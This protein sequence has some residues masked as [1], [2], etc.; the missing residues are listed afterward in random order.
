MS[1]RLSQ[2]LFSIVLGLA[3]AFAV[4]SPAFASAPA[5]DK[6]TAK[7]EIDFMQD[8]IDHHMMA[9]MMAEMCVEKAVHEELRLMCEEIIATQSQEMMMM[10]SWLQDWYGITYMPEM[11]QNGAIHHL[12][13]MEGAEFEI[14]FMQM[15]IKHHLGAIKEGEK[16]L[17]R[18]Y[19]PELLSLCQNIIVTQ[20]Q[21]IAQM[22]T[23][24]CE[25]YGI[26]KDYL[27]KA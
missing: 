8:M 17:D 21:E 1:T 24:L 6:S 26:C 5:P 23:W 25:W 13:I 10:Q 4:V 14:E 2:T 3:L 11:K 9:V 7:F 12:M 18:A 22:Q 20:T 19:H 27:K 16:C 15:M